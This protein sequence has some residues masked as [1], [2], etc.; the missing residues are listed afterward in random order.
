[1]LCSIADAALTDGW[2]GRSSDGKSLRW[3]K[4]RRT[5][6]WQNTGD[7]A[8]MP[9]LKI[10]NARLCVGRMTKPAGQIQNLFLSRAA[11]T[12]VFALMTLRG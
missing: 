9:R 7:E 11:Q 10:L 12:A 5:E 1:L 6:V 4:A 2:R 3:N 8:A